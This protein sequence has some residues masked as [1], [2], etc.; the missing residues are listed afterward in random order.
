MV[1]RYDDSDIGP[2]NGLPVTEFLY[3]FDQVCHVLGITMTTLK[4]IV[5]FEHLGARVQ[6]RQKEQ[7]RAINVMP[8]SWHEEK[9]WRVPESELVKYLDGKGLVIYERRIE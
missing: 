4:K 3:T 2:R 7:L 6:D 9:E 5:H 8:S 1:V